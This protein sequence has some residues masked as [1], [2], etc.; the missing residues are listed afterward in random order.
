[1]QEAIEVFE[2][3]IAEYKAERAAATKT[4]KG[5]KTAN[6]TKRAGGK[7]DTQQGGR[8]VANNTTAA[9]TQ[10]GTCGS[11]YVQLEKE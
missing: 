1:M 5:A 2:A 7:S 8:N 4:T 3:W 6:G 9:T 11:R 10:Q